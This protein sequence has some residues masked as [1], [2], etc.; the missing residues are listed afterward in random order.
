ML[1]YHPAW[2]AFLTKMQTFKILHL[3]YFCMEESSQYII[4]GIYNTCYYQTN[5]RHVTAKE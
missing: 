4:A 3:L 1:G 2:C 5:I